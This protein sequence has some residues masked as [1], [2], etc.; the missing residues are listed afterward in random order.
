MVHHWEK[1]H[2]TRSGYD[3][4]LQPIIGPELT[5][6]WNILMR[7][8][9]LWPPRASSE[10]LHSSSHCFSRKSTT[11][12]MLRDAAGNWFVKDCFASIKEASLPAS[13]S[14]KDSVPWAVKRAMTSLTSPSSCHFSSD[15]HSP[16][17]I[18]VSKLFSLH[19]ISL[20]ACKRLILANVKQS[21]AKL[22]TKEVSSVGQKLKAPYSSH[23]VSHT[24]ISW[25]QRKKNESQGHGGHETSCLN[26][27]LSGKSRI[28]PNP[29]EVLIKHMFKP[30]L[31]YD[32][33]VRV[34][35]AWMELHGLK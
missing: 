1:T 30:A 32:N 26:Y 33:I 16:S 20:A 3:S 28:R 15:T 29:L 8:S 31:T 25:R 2:P 23:D 34:C 9:L 19:V 10:A 12:A 14:L 35:S 4:T 17:R 13:S 18:H 27:Y 5:Q 11:H 6:E 7:S 24:E 22:A 21:L